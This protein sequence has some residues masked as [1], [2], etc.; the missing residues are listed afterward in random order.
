MPDLISSSIRRGILGLGQTGLSVA[1]FWRD[2]GLP[3]IA[4]DTRA[5]LQSDLGLRRE[6]AGVETH[7]GELNYILGNI[8]SL[9]SIEK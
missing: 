5:E 4:M 2:Q 3:F 6:L 9:I 1:R 7:F 8:I